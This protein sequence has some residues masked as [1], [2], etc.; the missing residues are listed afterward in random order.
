MPEQ[1]L[2]YQEVRQGFLLIRI[3]LEQN[4]LLGI[5]PVQ[6][7]LGQRFSKARVV[8]TAQKRTQPG[9]SLA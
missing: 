3:Y 2:R 8:Q 5:V 9:I 7:G 1:L 6:D 4:H